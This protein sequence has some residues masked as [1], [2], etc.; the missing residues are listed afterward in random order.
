MR[1]CSLDLF[2]KFHEISAVFSLCSANCMK[3]QHFFLIGK[4]YGKFHEI[5]RRVNGRL[6]LDNEGATH[7]QHV[8]VTFVT[9]GILLISGTY[10]ETHRKHTVCT[11]HPMNEPRAR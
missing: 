5:L 3:L 6:T 4:F 2:G 10:S 8:N 1:T 7:E 11:L 9:Q